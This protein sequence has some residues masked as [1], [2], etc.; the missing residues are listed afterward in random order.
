FLEMK[1]HFISQNISGKYSAITP[2]CST[3]SPDGLFFLAFV[4][5][6]GTSFFLF[7]N[8]DLAA[9]SVFA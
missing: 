6:C 8:Y 4:L 1:E 7:N 5:C 3:P 9:F 2:L